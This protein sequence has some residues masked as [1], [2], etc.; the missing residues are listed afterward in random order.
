M[1]DTIYQFENYILSYNTALLDSEHHLTPEIKRIIREIYPSVVNGKKQV[2]PRLK[3]LMERYPDVP[4]FKNY[5]ARIYE[6]NKDYEKAVDTN[7]ALIK[8]HPEYLYGKLNRA[9]GF[10]NDDNPEQIPGI[11]GAAMDLK[12][13][14]P[15]RNEFHYEEFIDFN[16]T[17]IRYFIATLN[18]QEARKYIDIMLDVAPEHPKTKAVDEYYMLTLMIEAK[19]RL[20]KEREHRIAVE[21]KD[22]LMAIQTTAAP[23]FNFPEQMQWLYALGMDIPKEKIESILA[24]EKDPLLDDLCA[25][26]RDSMVRYKVF[27]EDEDYPEASLDFPFHALL[28]LSE[29]G[30]KRAVPQILDLMRQDDDFMDFW[31]GDFIDDSVVPA[32]ALCSIENPQE[33]LAYLKEPNINGFNKS[34]VASALVKIAFHAPHKKDEIVEL[35]RELLEFFAEN[36]E[37]E[38]LVDTDFLGLLVSDL[39]DAAFTEL[40]PEIKK[41]FDLDIVGEFISGDYESIANDIV[42]EPSINTDFLTLDIYAKYAYLNNIFSRMQTNYDRNNAEIFGGHDS[43]FST[44]KPNIEPI[45]KSKKV[46]R[47]D[48]C[49]CGS[50]KKYK[51]CCMNSD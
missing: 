48:L 23:S 1:Q 32:L 35:L 22:K 10:L 46:G 21:V 14:Y 25:I 17:A 24:L 16:Y 3:K 4:T 29:L 31:L 43:F 5:T 15:D 2:L 19:E 45:V 50:G 30:E 26:L 18:Y 49:P 42:E 7:D 51:K 44:P 20:E 6:A 27:S 37:D 12:T 38:N 11:L 8:E 28:L 13:L 33:L 41:L 36:P 39:T 9:E 40:L 34:N 47:N